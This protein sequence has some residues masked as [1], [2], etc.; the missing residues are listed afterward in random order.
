[1]STA[2]SA[3][4]PHLTVDARGLRCPLPVLRLA[5]AVR[6]LAPGTVAAVVATDP[7][8]RHDVPAWA[9]LR[10]HTVLEVREGEEETYEVVVRLGGGTSTGPGLDRPAG[11][12][13]ASS[14]GR[15]AR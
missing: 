9:R 1:M 15:R 8:V 3:D 6:D 13:V 5:A 14:A 11:D 2:D 12:G 4:L 10:G 7:A